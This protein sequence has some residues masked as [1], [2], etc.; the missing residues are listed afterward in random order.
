MKVLKKIGDFFVATVPFWIFLGVQLAVSFAA[1]IVIAIISVASGNFDPSNT[2]S[3]ISNSALLWISLIAN[4]VCFIAMFIEMKCSK[5]NFGDFR[6]V[7]QNG[8]TIALTVLFTAGVF[9][10]LQFANGVFL[11]LIG[12][13]EADSTQEMLSESIVFTA[14]I[15]LT[16][17][18][19][20][21]LCFRGLMVKGFEKRFPKWFSITA[22][23]VLFMLLHSANM[24]PYALL[25]GLTLMLL[26]YKFGDW[27]LCLI[28]HFIANGMSCL[29]TLVPEDIINLDWFMPI[30]A[31][32]GLVVA[33]AAFF[34]MTKTAVKPSEASVQEENIPSEENAL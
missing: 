34:L 5:L 25:F 31:G 24:K 32:V 27:L 1:G 7:R 10:V 13:T 15:A 17:P 20:E 12:V 11:T 29:L 23:T 2:E 18:F 28:F 21:E 22:V 8:K 6:K 3:I 4:I 26:L 19:C 30:C 9:F 33:A 16:A 14:L